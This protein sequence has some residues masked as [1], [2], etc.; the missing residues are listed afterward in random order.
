[1][2]DGVANNGPHAEVVVVP[3]NLCAKVPDR[4]SDEEAAST[5]PGAIGLKGIRLARPTLGEA[6]V[7]RLVRR[8]C[9]E[10]KE[11]MQPDRGAPRGR[12]RR[13]SA[14]VEGQGPSLLYG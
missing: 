2:G 6:F 3:M 9:P 13:R 11:V 1:V 4:I 12:S 14:I 5:V 8:I 10:C 7:V